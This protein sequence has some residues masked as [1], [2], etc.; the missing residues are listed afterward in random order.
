[1]KHGETDGQTQA[2]HDTLI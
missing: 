2:S 1:M